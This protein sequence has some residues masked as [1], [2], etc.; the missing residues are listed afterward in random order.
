LA[1]TLQ[2]RSA[3]LWNMYGPTE[4][5]IWSAVQPVKTADLALTPI[6]QPIANTQVY[7]LDSHYNPAPI[8]IPG[9][10]YIGGD[11]L[12]R[13][14]LNRPDLSAERFI[15]NPFAAVH[16]NNI[17]SRLYRTGDIA[18]WLPSGSL[19]FMGRVDHQVKVR[20]FRI[21]LGEIEV[22]LKD[23]PDIGEAIVIAA[24]ADKNDATAGSPKSALV[25]YV[26][27]VAGATPSV[28][29]LRNFLKTKLPDYMIPTIFI[30]LAALP[31]TPNGKVD[32]VALPQPDGL[33]PTIEADYIAPRN[34]VEQQVADIWQSVLKLEQVGI[35]DNFFDLGGHS[36]LLMQVHNRLQ[37]TFAREIPVLDLF[38]YSN[39][40]LLAVYLSTGPVEETAPAADPARVEVRRT[41]RAQQRQSSLQRRTEFRRNRGANTQQE[42]IDAE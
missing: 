33:R 42:I 13:G 15:P 27:P 25:A 36:L 28:S 32:R 37:E 18:R 41:V 11:G 6:G 19:E 7:I 24:S 17:G 16:K 26:V 1:Q 39:V 23:H 29:T 38:K 40:R 3:S 5:T 22:A 31:L 8:G 10:L 35:N 34:D 14:Y 20:G 2:Q 12:A 30:S 9:E 21:E 4:T